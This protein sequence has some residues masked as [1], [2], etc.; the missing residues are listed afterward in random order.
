L[1]KERIYKENFEIEEIKLRNKKG[2]GQVFQ[3]ERSQKAQLKL[4]VL[5]ALALD[6]ELDESVKVAND[7]FREFNQDLFDLFAKKVQVKNGLTVAQDRILFVEIVRLLKS[8]K[9]FK[10]ISSEEQPFIRSKINGILGAKELDDYD[11]E[12]FQKVRF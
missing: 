6:F 12:Q 3:T 1:L 8:S 7:K 9:V 11:L 10:D 2:A 5:D 4:K